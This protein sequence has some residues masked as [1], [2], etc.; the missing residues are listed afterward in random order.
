MKL[1][2]SI[3]FGQTHGAT[4]KSAIAPKD[5][6]LIKAVLTAGLYPNIGKVGSLI[7]V[8]LLNKYSFPV[9]KVP[10]CAVY[11]V[12]SVHYNIFGQMSTM[13]FHLL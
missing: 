9:R 12:I 13:E 11:R 8:I 7:H 5:G 2:H 1:L 10:L 3:G 6:S 4:S